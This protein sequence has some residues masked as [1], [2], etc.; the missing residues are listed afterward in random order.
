MAGLKKVKLLVFLCLLFSVYSTSDTFEKD[1]RKEFR[2]AGINLRLDR[3]EELKSE[4]KIFDGFVAD[5]EKAAECGI[6]SSLG[7]KL[8]RNEIVY[9]QVRENGELRQIYL[10][11]LIL[12][13]RHKITKPDDWP[14][15][16][17]LMSADERKNGVKICGKK[18][19]ISTE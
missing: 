14:H 17:L 16:K 12:R 8:D 7:E 9:F 1:L 11:H 2:L 4:V 19:S 6:V 10:G 3:D 13:R 5:P 15:S 18:D